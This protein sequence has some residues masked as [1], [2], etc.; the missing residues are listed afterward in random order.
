V[1]AQAGVSEVTL[2]DDIKLFG[3]KELHR[4]IAHFL[5]IRFPIALALNKI[6]Q[7]VTRH[8]FPTQPA[9][10]IYLSDVSLT[11]VVTLHSCGGVL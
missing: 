6:D 2:A 9:L 1:H 8:P 10:N 5:R 3:A 4:I 11:V 7:P